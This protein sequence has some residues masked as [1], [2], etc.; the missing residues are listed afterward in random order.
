MLLV[1][2]ATSTPQVRSKG[3]WFVKRQS[4]PSQLYTHRD[5]GN[6]TESGAIAFIYIPSCYSNVT[7]CRGMCLKPPQNSEMA[8]T[9]PKLKFYCDLLPLSTSDPLKILHVARKLQGTSVLRV[10]FVAF[11]D[12]TGFQARPAWRSRNK[13]APVAAFSSCTGQAPATTGLKCVN[14]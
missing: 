1:L 9:G 8:A 14:N 11:K 13:Q 7:Q 6:F 5:A 12:R 10:R 4:K 3:Q 2:I